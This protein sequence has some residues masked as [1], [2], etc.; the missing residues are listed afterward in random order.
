M[1]R[2]VTILIHILL[3]SHCVWAQVP[4]YMGKRI[5]VDA[6]FHSMANPVATLFNEDYFREYGIR[7]RYKW[8]LQAE[9]TLTKK[10]T[11]G[12]Q[13]DLL[14]QSQTTNYI[15]SSTG[16]N[17]DKSVQNIRL[18]VRGL[19]IGFKKYLKGAMAP[20]GTYLQINLISVTGSFKATNKTE[21]WNEQYNPREDDE[22]IIYSSYQNDDTVSGYV[23]N[24]GVGKRVVFAD[25]FTFQ[26]GINVGGLGYIK[27]EKY[28]TAPIFPIMY[29]SSS[30]NR[31]E[32]AGA[33]A[34]TMI[35][36]NYVVNASI[37][38]G[39]LL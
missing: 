27:S 1:K 10:M 22:Q 9:Y 19:G 2:I 4:G 28:G 12:L 17:E 33:N 26:F 6:N 31:E 23:L 35:K 11:I 24:V 13:Y 20:T 29:Y 32:E 25:R 8:N 21:E 5:A 16:N 7:F 30:S 39:I 14:N 3:F 36:R 38:F 37:G 18:Q 15:L 34:V